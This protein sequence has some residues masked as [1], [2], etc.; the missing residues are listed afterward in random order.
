[1]EFKI[2]N[3]M[4]LNGCPWVS[5]NF[6]KARRDPSSEG[7]IGF[8]SFYILNPRGEGYGDTRGACHYLET[9]GSSGDASVPI[10]FK[11]CYG[12]VTNELCFYTRQL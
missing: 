6:T 5:R 11:G 8:P 9:Y 7:T 3:Y 12:I 10:V 4:K 1:M 2:T